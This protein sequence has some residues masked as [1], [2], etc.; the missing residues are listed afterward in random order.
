MVQ[1]AFPPCVETAGLG[2]RVVEIGNGRG[3]V[4]GGVEAGRAVVGG[5]VGGTGTVVA[6]VGA[7]DVGAMVVAE[8]AGVV[9]MGTVVVR[10][11]GVRSVTITGGAVGE[12][13]VGREETVGRGAVVT[14][15]A[16]LVA[17]GVQIEDEVV[18]TVAWPITLTVW[19]GVG[20]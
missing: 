2:S 18:L 16:S 10:A 19:N 14:T 15:V 12:R 6:V 1:L 13:V 17:M 20:V 11:A 4:V 5:A 8:V 9:T 7:T 3:S